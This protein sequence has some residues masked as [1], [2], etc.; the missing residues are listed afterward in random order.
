METVKGHSRKLRITL[1]ECIGTALFV[2][3]FLVSYAD[4][5]AASLALFSMML[6]FGDITGGHFNPAVSLAVY[7]WQDH[8]C[9]NL[10]FLFMVLTAQLAGGFLGALLAYTV[11]HVEGAVP[12]EYVPILV[13]QNDTATAALNGFTMD[14]QT[15]F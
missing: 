1:Y 13:P 12:K 14:V 4:A 7:V 6:V 5:L 9:K 2:Y 3:C 10:C 8:F 15:F 11:L